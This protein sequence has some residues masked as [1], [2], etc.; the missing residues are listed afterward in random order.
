MRT[1]AV[2]DAD[3]SYTY[4]DFERFF[5]E[6]AR[7]LRP[8]GHFLYADFRNRDGIPAWRQL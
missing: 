4:R 3:A 2:I 8:G 7:V 5:G 6:V 1:D